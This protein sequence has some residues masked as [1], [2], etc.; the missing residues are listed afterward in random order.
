MASQGYRYAIMWIA[1]RHAEMP[2]DDVRM[3]V[4]KFVADIFGKDFDHVDSDVA[5]FIGTMKPSELP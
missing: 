1:R 3:W 2:S 4:I 5:S